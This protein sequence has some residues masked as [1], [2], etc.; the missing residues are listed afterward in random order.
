MRLF[1]PNRSQGNG[2][3]HSSLLSYP[4]E[5][6]AEANAVVRFEYFFMRSIFNEAS[7]ESTLTCTGLQRVPAPQGRDVL[8][9]PRSPSLARYAHGLADKPFRNVLNSIAIEQFVSPLSDIADMR[10]REHIVE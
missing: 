1:A 9:A 2:Q 3:H 10:R 5:R 8:R 7:R 6:I 4:F